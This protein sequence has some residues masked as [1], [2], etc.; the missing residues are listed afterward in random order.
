MLAD[1]ETDFVKN[2]R[3]AQD[4][5]EHGFLWVSGQHWIP[6]CYRT[7]RRAPG[8]SERLLQP[9]RCGGPRPRRGIRP[10]GQPEILLAGCGPSRCTFQQLL[11][12]LG[13]PDRI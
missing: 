12:W 6:P 5:G 4:R 10:L 1:D 9:E 3:P 11:T 2:S 7:C 8:A 13:Y